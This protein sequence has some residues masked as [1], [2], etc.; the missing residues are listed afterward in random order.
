MYHIQDTDNIRQALDQHGVVCIHKEPSSFTPN[1]HILL[2]EELGEIE[3]TKFFRSVPSYPNIALVEK[4]S[5]QTTAIGE[6]LHSDHTYDLSPAMGAVLVA[7]KLPKKGGDTIFVDMRAAYDNL[8]ESVKIRIENLRAY[9]SCQHTFREQTIIGKILQKSPYINSKQ[10]TTVLHPIV[11]THPVSGR[12]SLFVNPVFTIGIEGLA[13]KESKALLETL[14]N[15]AIQPKHLIRFSWKLGDTL[16]W[17]NRSVW[18]LAVNDYQGQHR[19]MH[20]ISINGCQLRDGLGRYRSE[21][22]DFPFDPLALKPGSTPFDLPY[23]KLLHNTTNKCIQN[24]EGPPIIPWWHQPPSLIGD[25]FLRMASFV[26]I[27]FS[28][29]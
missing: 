12:K 16:I 18:H 28:K 11:I 29:L 6:F 9:H 10:T 19:I 14:Y 23:I 24:V 20:R 27:N 3:V 21:V 13:S 26:G 5:S 4:K 8:H 22:V 25:M 15:S 7:R 2:A 17:D 1:R